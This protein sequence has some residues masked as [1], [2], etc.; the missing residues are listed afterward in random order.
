MF[1]NPHVDPADDLRGLD[2]FAEL[3]NE[4]LRAAAQHADWTIVTA[5]TRLQKRDMTVQW[6]WIAADDPLE[7]QIEG[8]A[9][10]RVQ[11]GNAFGE[12]F[13]LLDMVSPVDVVATVDTRAVSLPARAF[14]G[15]LSDARFATQAARRQARFRVAPPAPAIRTAFALERVTKPVSPS[16]GSSRTV[17]PVTSALGGPCRHHATSASTAPV[18][19]SATTSTRPSSRLRAQPATPRRWASRRHDAR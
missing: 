5:G 7:L 18:G 4:Q 6:L 3:P 10:D 13:L 15:L 14:H 16:G 2:Y 1:R 12:A 9:V 8:V 19:P 11:P 17:T